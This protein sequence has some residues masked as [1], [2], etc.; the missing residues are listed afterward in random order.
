MFYGG[1]RSQLVLPPVVVEEAILVSEEGVP[2]LIL[3][4]V[5]LNN[6]A[7]AAE[8]VEMEPSASESGL[9]PPPGFPP[10]V[11]PEYDGGMDIDDLCTRF[12]G[13]SSLTLSPISRGSSDL[14]DVVSVSITCR[15]RSY[16]P[17]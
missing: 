7:P 14:S 5:E 10:F 9:P 13:D 11:W 17:P 4:V 8:L 15:L 16:R 1:D 3:P 6:D 12:S 2:S